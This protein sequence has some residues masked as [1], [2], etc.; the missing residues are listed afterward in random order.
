[1]KRYR[2]FSILLGIVIVIMTVQAAKLL[3]AEPSTAPRAKD[4]EK[5]ARVAIDEARGADERER[6]SPDRA[7]ASGNGVVEPKQP[8]T[9]LG[10]PMAGQL[11]SISIEEGD[12]V[13]AGQVVAEIDRRVEAAALAAAEADAAAA[14]AELDRVIGGSRAED[15]RAA[16]AEADGARARAT[17]AASVAQRTERAANAGALTG[18]ELERAKREAEAADA[19]LRVATAREQAIIAGSRREDIQLARARVLAADARRDQAK[20]AFERLQITSPINGEVLQVRYRVGEFYQPDGGPIAI[21]GD[22]SRLRARVDIDERDIARVKLGQSVLVRASAYAVDVRGKIVE[23]GRRM[24]RKNVRT[25]DPTER[26]DTK[27]LET[28][29]ELDESTPFVVGQRVTCYVL[30]SP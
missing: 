25:D 8:E 16:R 23:L 1:M 9:R 30:A 20:A 27:I 13:I 17:L 29:V 3:R 28:V 6:P 24:G 12:K 5:A 19:A 26:N 15:I 4:V 7:V 2:W 18:E 11:T 14:R 21:I 22:T 10:A